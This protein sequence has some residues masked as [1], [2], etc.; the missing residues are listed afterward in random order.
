MEWGCFEKTRGGTDLCS[1][2]RVSVP[3]SPTD[4]RREWEWRR[5]VN[6]ESERFSRG[7]VGEEG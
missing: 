3:A 1:F 6:L 5:Y 4:A 7:D 2:T